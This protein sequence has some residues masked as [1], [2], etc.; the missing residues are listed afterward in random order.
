VRL[1]KK[2][3]IDKLREAV[4]QA[5][6]P[7]AAAFGLSKLSSGNVRYESG[8]AACTMQLRIETL[9]DGKSKDEL[10]WETHHRLFDLPAD[11]LH[12]R[13]CHGNGRSNEEVEII[14]LCPNRFKFPVLVKPTNG[15]RKPFLLTAEEVRRKL[16]HKPAGG[17]ELVPPPPRS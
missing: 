2:D 9:V 12:K 10:A 6:A 15:S 13:F 7:V 16:G 3:D 8:G 1:D 14:G 4:N 11:G 5:L 17:L